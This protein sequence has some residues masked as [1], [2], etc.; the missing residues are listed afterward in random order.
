MKIDDVSPAAATRAV[1]PATSAAVNGATASAV[2]PGEPSS[3]MAGAGD[4]ATVSAGASHLATISDVRTEK[5]T[6][7]QQALAAGTYR[8]NAGDLADSLMAS[9]MRKPG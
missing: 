9:M 2:R 6:E 4:S 1:S 3:A 7:V 5:V 8:V